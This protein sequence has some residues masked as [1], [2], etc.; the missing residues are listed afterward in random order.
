MVRLFTWTGL[1]LSIAAVIFLAS[2]PTARAANNSEQIVFSGGGS[3]PGVTPFGFWIWCEGDSANPYQGECNGA[4]YFYALGITKHV[5]GMVT[6]IAEGIY[7]MSVVSTV[8]DSVAC[9]L[10]NSAPPVNGPHNSNRHLHRTLCGGQHH[11]NV[12]QL[13][14]QRD[15]PLKF[16]F[17]YQRIVACPGQSVPGAPSAGPGAAGLG[18][19]G[20]GS[21]R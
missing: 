13:S 21:G 4:M 14:S 11:R 19:G 6:E 17:S 18:T 7:Q 12:H 1:L 5:A 16:A 9:T 2:A 3:F 8:D 15:W 20:P 10:V